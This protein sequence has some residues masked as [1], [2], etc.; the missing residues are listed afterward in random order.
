MKNPNITVVAPDMN[1]IAGTFVDRS[2]WV[3]W[4]QVSARGGVALPAEIT[5]FE[6]PIGKLDPLTES[7][8]TLH[9]T[10]MRTCGP[11]YG[12]GATRCMFLRDLGIYF[13]LWMSNAQIDA[14]LSEATLRF[15][16]CEKVFYEH[17]FD[18]QEV[19]ELRNGETIETNTYPGDASQPDELFDRA[20]FSER[21]VRITSDSQ[22]FCKYIA[23]MIPFQFSIAFQHPPV[24]DFDGIKPVMVAVMRGLTDRAVQ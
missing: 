3:Y 19:R 13:P 24:L 5:A 20:A 7:P 2:P 12:F 9:H 8:K 15:V 1:A 17:R 6:I 22:Q 10:N 21:T 16:I 18:L 23:P 4:D 14:I 11:N